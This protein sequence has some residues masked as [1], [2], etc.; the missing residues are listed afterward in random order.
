VS[1]V[2]APPLAGI[3]VIDL[4]NL[5]P[6]PYATMILGDF[7]AD[8]IKVERP[9]T[10]DPGR[11]S[12]PTIDGISTRHMMVNRNKRSIALDLHDDA[13]K[14]TMLTL[15][16]DADVLVEGFRPGSMARLGLGYDHL[17]TLN[18]RLVYCSING[19]GSSGGS[20][21]TDPPAHDLNFMA[22]AG[23]LAP[24]PESGTCQLPAT[25]F[26]DLAAGSMNAVIGI[27]MALFA[28][29]A[30]GVGQHVDVAMMPG[31]LALQVEALAY[32]NAGQPAPVGG[33]RLTGRYPC[34]QVYKTLDDRFMA[35]GATE[36]EFWANL[37]NLL[38][39]PEL[40]DQQYAEGD[41][42]EAAV[43]ALAARF[44]T[45]SAEQWEM[46]LVGSET[47]CT[48][49]LT[50][51]EAIERATSAAPGLLVEHEDTHGRALRQFLSAC[52]LSRTPAVHRTPAPLLDANGDEIRSEVRDSDRST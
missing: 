22:L 20:E 45:R 31:A 34:Y 14:A 25:Q 6:G 35:V 7:G 27:L 40:I 16:A 38:Q 32:L 51:A 26:A 37:C 2:A 43:A 33:M 49:V 8:V 18:P 29:Q 24:D 10:G 23:L 41:A 39:V 1:S 12:R 44:S 9:P 13:D 28:R 48:P 5:L 17:A 19:F 30:S 21:R 3:R 52:T 15:C 46:T 11:A 47:C 4:T 50:P 36:P 42:G